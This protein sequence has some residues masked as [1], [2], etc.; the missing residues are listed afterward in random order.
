MY[1]KGKPVVDLCCKTAEYKDYNRDSLQI[2]FR[3]VV[4]KGKKICEV[5][6]ESIGLKAQK[7]ACY[8][9]LFATFTECL[10]PE[11][12]YYAWNYFNAF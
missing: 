6:D 10:Y 8:L 2:L 7:L 9:I 12:I 3:L 11:I 4:K 5:C 1:V